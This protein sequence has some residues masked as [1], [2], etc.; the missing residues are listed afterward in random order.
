MTACSGVSVRMQTACT[1]WTLRGAVALCRVAHWATLQ[2]PG[3]LAAPVRCH[4][5]QQVRI[6]SVS[7]PE[8]RESGPGCAAGAPPV[9]VSV[10]CLRQIPQDVLM[11]PQLDLKAEPDE[12]AQHRADC[13]EVAIT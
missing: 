13:S 9:S 7:S 6:C 10:H 8:R 11:A 12:A 4:L 1:P 2:S 3:S 5:A